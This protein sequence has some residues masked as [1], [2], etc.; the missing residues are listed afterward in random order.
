M[1]YS[2]TGLLSHSWTSEIMVIL[3]IVLITTLFLAD[4]IEYQYH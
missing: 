2:L 3:I 1:F 4:V